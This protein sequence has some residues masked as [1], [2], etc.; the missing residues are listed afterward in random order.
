MLIRFLASHPFIK[1]DPDRVG[2]FIF[3]NKEKEKDPQTN[4]TPIPTRVNKGIERSGG[5]Q[6]SRRMEEWV[7][8]PPNRDL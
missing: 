5:F 3:Q 4:Q 1:R 6:R 2:N 7:G 8:G